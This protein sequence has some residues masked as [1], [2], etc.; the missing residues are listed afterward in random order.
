MKYSFPEY[1]PYTNQAQSEQRKQDYYPKTA[2]VLERHGIP[3]YSTVSPFV[4]NSASYM[5]KPLMNPN[6]TTTPQTGTPQTTMPQTGTPAA[7]RSTMPPVGTPAVP[8]STMPPTTMPP[9]GTPAPSTGMPGM[10]TPST[11]TPL[12]NPP[13]MP[14]QP[15]NMNPT[16]S[17]EYRSRNRMR[18]GNR[19]NCGSNCSD[20]MDS[21]DME[22]SP[23]RFPMGVP[24]MPLYGYDNCEDADKDWDYFRQ[25]YPIAARRIMVE[26]DDECD[27]LEYDGSCMFDEYPDRVHLG[28]IIDRI[29]DK[30]KDMEDDSTTHTESIDSSSD[31]SFDDSSLQINQFNRDRN[32]DRDRDRDYDRDRNR[33]GRDNR[34]NLRNLIEVLFFNELLNRRRRFRGRRRW[35]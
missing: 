1:S 12:T 18:Y 14:T 21:P 20:F 13:V 33:R 11:P 7:P 26:I 30:V 4:N 25:M 28:R 27:K 17:Q 31:H 2:Q 29:F 16:Q 3:D 32:R 15:S 19:N 8:R 23:Y 34:S 9:T 5:R 35:F 10:T 24:M 22:M 6:A